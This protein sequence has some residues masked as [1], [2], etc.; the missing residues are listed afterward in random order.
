MSPRPFQRS[1]GRCP[2]RSCQLDR[3][4]LCVGSLRQ[5]ILPRLSPSGPVQAMKSHRKPLR[6]AIVTT[7]VAAFA[8]SL[9]GVLNAL[10]GTPLAIALALLAVA[11]ASLLDTHVPWRRSKIICDEQE[12]R[13]CETSGATSVLPWSD[14]ARACIFPLGDLFI[15]DRFG[16]CCI[17]VP[18][19]HPELSEIISRLPGIGAVRSVTD[20]ASA[21]VIMTVSVAMISGVFGIDQWIPHLAG[22]VGFVFGAT[23]GISAL[24]ELFEMRYLTE[25]QWNARNV[26]LGLAIV[27]ATVLYWIVTPGARPG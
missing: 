18:S 12:I 22:L 1:G 11:A 5:A 4:D 10:H 6:V 7:A 2:G 26:P 13:I 14:V 9:V 15:Q 24:R 16:K 3:R 25:G 21:T 27:A 23:I 19:G 8:A 17:R 20:P